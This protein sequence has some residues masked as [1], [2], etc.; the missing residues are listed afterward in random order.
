MLV[1]MHQAKTRLSELV[2][3]ALSGEEV[4]IARDE[5]PVV[6]LVPIRA[7][8]HPQPGGMAEM[9]APMAAERFAPLAPAELEALGFGAFLDVG[10]AAPR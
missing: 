6:R 2:E 4:V 7:P 5:R 10:R 9:L 8:D 3:R 1:K